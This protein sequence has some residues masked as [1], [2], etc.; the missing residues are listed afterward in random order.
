MNDCA[1]IKDYIRMALLILAII[2]IFIY[3]WEKADYIVV[4]MINAMSEIVC[5]KVF[6]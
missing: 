5:N 2:I 1:T 3:L 6:D 4:K